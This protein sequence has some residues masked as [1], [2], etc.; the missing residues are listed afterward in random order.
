[1]PKK[2]TQAAP[3]SRQMA[4]RMPE[5]LAQRIETAA[6]HL[7]TDSSHLIRMVVAEHLGEYEQ[8]AERAARGARPTGG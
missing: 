2:R 8:R 7:G 1:M 5:P 4:V 6:G 3:A